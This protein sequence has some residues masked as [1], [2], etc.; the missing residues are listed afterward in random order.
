[1]TYLVKFTNEALKD[2]DAHKKAG[3]RNVLRRIEALL[4]ELRLHPREGI[5]R[6]EKLKHNLA[7][8]YSR[9]ITSKHRLVYEIEDEIVTVVVVGAYGHYGDH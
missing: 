3:D 6:P 2:I 9:R 7:G 5:G 8:L 1:M 4:L